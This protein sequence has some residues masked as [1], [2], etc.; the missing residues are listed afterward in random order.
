MPLARP[1]YYYALKMSPSVIIFA[2]V[3]FLDS[4]S[5]AMTTTINAG[6]YTENLQRQQTIPIF[7]WETIDFDERWPRHRLRL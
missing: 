6:F 2:F 3:I 1:D 4:V 5:S 7:R